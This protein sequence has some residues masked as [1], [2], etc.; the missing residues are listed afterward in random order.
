MIYQ[1]SLGL[2]APALADALEAMQ[3]DL[4]QAGIEFRRS[5]TWRDPARQAALFAQGRT[6]PGDIVTYAP[7]ESSPHCTIKGGQPFALAADYIVYLNGKPAFGTTPP[8]FEIWDCFGEIAEDNGLVWGGRFTK[9]RDAC[10]V[11]VPH[12][13]AA[14]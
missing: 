1:K 3:Y 11:E 13:R 6:A 4:L 7:P 10:H 14:L 5:E 9:I 12:W 8:E 2:C